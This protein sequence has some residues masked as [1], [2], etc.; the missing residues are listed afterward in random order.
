MVPAIKTPPAATETLKKAI[1]ERH[2]N[3]DLHLMTWIVRWYRRRKLRQAQEEFVYWKARLDQ[4]RESFS[5]PF[6]RA[7]YANE[8]AD[9]AGNEAKFA[10][11]VEQLMREL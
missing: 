6:Q 5:D 10:E 1:L 2:V 3:P 4:L 11:R 7:Y 9:A 8:L